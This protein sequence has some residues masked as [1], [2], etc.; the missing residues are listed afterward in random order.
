MDEASEALA[1]KLRG[2]EYGKLITAAHDAQQ[3]QMDLCMWR[4][5]A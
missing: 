4:I 2:G 3:A 1:D 5:T